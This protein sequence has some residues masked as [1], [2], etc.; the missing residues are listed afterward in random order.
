[1]CSLK[2]DNLLVTD[3]SV[4]PFTFCG[5]MAVTAL[6]GMEVTSDIVAVAEREMLRERRAELRDILARCTPRD[7]LLQDVIALIAILGP[8]ALRADTTTSR[9]TTPPLHV[10]R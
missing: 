10:V 4:A 8:V 9:T 5:D 7:L 1:M 3:L 6:Q 2:A